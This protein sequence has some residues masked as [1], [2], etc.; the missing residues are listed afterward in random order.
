M[1]TETFMELEEAARVVGGRLSRGRSRLPLS[2][3]FTDT[4]RPLCGGLF[5]AL[6]GENFDGNTFAAAAL[7]AGA[8]AVV[9]DSEKVAVELRRRKEEAPEKG[10]IL[11]ADGRAA[12]LALAAAH[13][14]RLTQA[15]WFAVTG[16]AGKSTVKEMLAHILES[17]AGWKTHRAPHSFNNE[18]GLS[19]TILGAGREH[20]AVVLELGANRPGEIASLAAA[21]RPE[22]AVVLNAG[23]VHLGGF[24]SVEDVARE[25][26]ALLDA[27]TGEAVFHLNA[28]EPFYKSWREQARKR[29]EKKGREL[30]FSRRA[31]PAAALW[32]EDV[33][34]VLHWENPAAASNPAGSTDAGPR[35]AVAGERL[36]P[37]ETRFRVRLRV[38]ANDPA[39]DAGDAAGAAEETVEVSLPLPGRHNAFNAAAALA[40]A[41]GAGV[42]AAAAAAAL[43]AF[44]GLSRRLTP[45][46][47]G[48][49]LL[50]DDAYNANPPAFEAALE[51]LAEFTD[52]RRFVIA[53]DMLELGGESE[54]LHRRLGRGLARVRPAGIVTVGEAA[55]VAGEEAARVAGTPW[56]KAASPE[57]AAELLLPRLQA[58]DVVLLKGS[59]AVRLDRALTALAALTAGPA[60]SL[61]RSL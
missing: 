16:S 4:R 6:R 59:H 19:A 7:A 36:S 57:E 41:R 31:A 51:V 60:D 42:S 54:E 38:P 45:R 17:G 15:R 29:T 46:L 12:Y 47:I 55:A 26:G 39:G 44:Q 50:L 30:S 22:T 9:V 20:R 40:A 25:K 28:D 43:A 48:G 37:W 5:L 3:V 2:G 53:G 58:G 11:V 61:P 8:A 23:P 14:R 21:A 13:R 56:T 33:R 32:I 24:G 10:I 1:T 27:L 35:S 18:V 34:T 49:V 52:R